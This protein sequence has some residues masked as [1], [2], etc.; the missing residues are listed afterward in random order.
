MVRQSLSGGLGLF[1]GVFGAYML[2]DSAGWLSL[3][4]GRAVSGSLPGQHFIYDVGLAFMAS[5]LGFVVAAVRP[6]WRGVSL[7]AAAFPAFHAAMHVLEMVQGGAHR[8]VFDLVAIV[9]PAL[10]G[11]LIG[12]SALR[13]R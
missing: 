3:M 1:F 4:I 2:L 13:E 9:A 7:V 6:Q 12:C 10:L 11:V 5:G 8:L